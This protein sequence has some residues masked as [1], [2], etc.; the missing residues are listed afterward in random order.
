MKKSTIL[1]LI[2]AVLV[3][4]LVVGAIVDYKANQ[5]SRW[6]VS[7]ERHCFL[8]ESDQYDTHDIVESWKAFRYLHSNQSAILE[9]GVRDQDWVA[10]HM[11]HTSV[12]SLIL[13]LKQAQKQGKSFAENYYREPENIY[14]GLVDNIYTAAMQR[15]VTLGEVMPKP[16]TEESKRLIV[17]AL[18]TLRD[19]QD[20]V[21]GNITFDDMSLEDKEYFYGDYINLIQGIKAMPINKE[22]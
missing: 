12:W 16:I 20:H 7:L 5:E 18:E 10:V 4:W 8:I 1:V 19:V 3:A 21:L 13:L 15:G 2:G 11:R 22:I 14:T 9:Q 17:S 6:L